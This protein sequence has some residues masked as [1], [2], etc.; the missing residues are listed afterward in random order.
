M[1][2]LNRAFSVVYCSYP[3]MEYSLH[4]NVVFQ[5]VLHR[6]PGLIFKQMKKFKDGEG[7]FFTDSLK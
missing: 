6:K 3:N 1:L 7:H 2:L 4:Q 5:G